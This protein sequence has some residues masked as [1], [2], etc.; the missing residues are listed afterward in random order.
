MVPREIGM[1]SEGNI[2]KRKS[3]SVNI[4]NTLKDK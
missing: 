1:M 3:N 4:H 2:K